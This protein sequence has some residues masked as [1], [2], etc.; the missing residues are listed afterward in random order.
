MH[1][2]S[3]NHLMCILPPDLLA[4]IAER[5]EARHRE[6]AIRTLLEDQSF[7][8]A[9]QGR[10]SDL[11][12]TRALRQQRGQNRPWWM[13]A[14][15]SPRRTIYSADNSRRLPGQ[16]VRSEGDPDSGDDAVDEAYDHLGATF[17]LYWDVYG[18]D[19]IDDKGLALNGIVH[20]AQDYDNAFWD[21][22][23]MV[24][25]DGDGE[26]FNRFT[27]PVDVVGHELT[28][29]VTGYESGLIYWGQAGAL[30]ESVSDV[31]GSLVK[32]YQLDQKASDADWLI[33]EGLFTD[34]VDG[35][36]LRSMAAPG[37]AYDDPV[38]GKDTQPADMSHYLHTFSDN[39]GVHTNSGI[40][41]HAF[42]LAA[43]NIGGYAWDV[44]GQVWYSALTGGQ[45][46]RSAQFSTFASLTVMVADDLF[47]D[48]DASDAI[49]DAWAEVGVRV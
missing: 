41:N 47:P 48:S 24:F 40:P 49:H 46:P 16:E 33:G 22:S 42:Y 13:A 1:G 38:L 31:F 6:R 39:G 26:L 21:G 17:Y 35:V 20:Y 43:T 32:Q 19:S 28:H 44:A 9:R 3:I 4:N 34:E 30:N 2:S 45:L 25:G 15:P 8:S 23:E 5:G 11:R 37:T 18:R 14:E 12:L 7:R 29:G 10:S 36:A 27:I